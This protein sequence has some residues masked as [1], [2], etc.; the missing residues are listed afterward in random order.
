MLKVQNVTGKEKA[1]AKLIELLGMKRENFTVVTTGNQ[2]AIAETENGSMKVELFSQEN[3]VT[4]ITAPRGPG[5]HIRMV[6]PMKDVFAPS[7]AIYEISAFDTETHNQIFGDV[8]SVYIGPEGI[9]LSEASLRLIEK[10]LEGE[11]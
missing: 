9:T 6:N 7:G 4:N 3:P 1:I 5:I 10:K 11:R 8:V 2:H